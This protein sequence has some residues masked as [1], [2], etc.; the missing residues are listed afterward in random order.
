M[1]KVHK[2]STINGRLAGI[3][4]VKLCNISRVAEWDAKLTRDNSKVTCTNCLKIIA[5]RKKP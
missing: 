5:E 3:H 1:K 2:R 4:I